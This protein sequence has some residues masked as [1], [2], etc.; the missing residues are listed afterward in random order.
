MICRILL[1]VLAICNTSFCNSKTSDAGSS[2]DIKVIAVKEKSTD[3]LGVCVNFDLG[4]KHV[5][6]KIEIT[7]PKEI[8]SSVILG[9]IEGSNSI[10][11][12]DAVPLCMIKNA[13]PLTG[14]ETI[15][16]DINVSSGYRY[17]RYICPAGMLGMFPEISF[18]GY[19][20]N[21]YEGIYYRP[22][23]LPLIT[24]HT[25]SNKEPTDKINYIDANVRV[26][27]AVGT[28]NLSASAKVRLR[29]NWSMTLP[30]K[31]YRI[32]FDKKQRLLD[33]KAKAKKWNLLNV[34]DDRTLLHNPIAFAVSEKIGLEYT[35]YCRHVDVMFNG[36]YKGCY[37]LCDQIEVGDNRVDI[38]INEDTSDVT[39]GYLVEADGYYESEPEYF[40]S[41]HGITLT[42]HYPKDDEISND[43]RKDLKDSF[44][45]MES[46]VYDNNEF[47]I[48]SHYDEL[49]DVSSFIKHLLTNEYMGN[50][51]TYWSTYMYKKSKNDK[52]FFGPVWDFDGAFDLNWR[53]KP[54]NEK[55]DF[56]F[57]WAL[58]AGS[59]ADLARIVIEDKNDEIK[60]QRI[61][62]R[63]NHILNPDSLCDFI[64]RKES[65]IEESARLN[66][67][68]WGFP[69]DEHK[70]EV[71]NIKEF[72]R[73]RTLWMDNFLRK[74]DSSNIMPS[75]FQK[76]QDKNNNVYNLN[77]VMILTGHKGSIVIKNKKKYVNVK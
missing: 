12:I 9:I 30:K 75:L 63:A 11:F 36:D 65:E 46:A 29:G 67:I 17:V 24:I 52:W 73:Q 1:T 61:S 60:S 32:K 34:Y 42:V 57:N 43:Q 15:K 6:K 53:V 5:I 14:Q 21:G 35:P 48:D 16:I 3:S 45:K 69:E 37:Q 54:V 51:D 38:E 47:G 8:G 59:M 71:S 39:G 40:I 56:C 26:I 19:A 62:L 27:S 49:L 7:I 22:T 31:P 25:Y 23:N 72:I 20:G 13:P 70:I 68:R 76:C 44:N 2:N 74:V 18:E 28:E 10:D 4:K 50:N 33:G 64:D 77:G 58:S 66:A 55:N 41:S